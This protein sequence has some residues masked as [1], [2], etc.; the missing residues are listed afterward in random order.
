VIK[1]GTKLNFLAGDRGSFWPAASASAS[2]LVSG[3]GMGWKTGLFTLSQL[4]V[5]ISLS[6]V[7]FFSLESF[8][9][10]WQEALRSC[11]FFRRKSIAY[12]PFTT[13][14]AVH[15]SGAQKRFDLDTPG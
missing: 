13:T 11:A 14:T 15:D 2:S 5:M 10:I 1:L 12:S 6:F 7:F 3:Q 8:V 9:L 4:L